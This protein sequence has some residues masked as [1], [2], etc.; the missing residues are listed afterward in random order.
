[1]IVVLAGG[2][3][4]ARF[5]EGVV[6]VVPPQEV[7]IISNTGD[8]L[9]FYGL[10]VCPDI[11]IVL[12]TLAGRLDSARGWGLLHDSF[13][14]LTSLRRFEP[15]VWFN[16]GDHDLATSLYRT[17]RLGEGATLTQLTAEIAAAQGLSVR[18]L[19]M[20]DE[21]VATR[22]LTPAGELAFQ[23]YFV[24]RRTEDEVLGIR[25]EGIEDARPVPGLLDAIGAAAA[26]IFAPSNPFVSIGPIL[27]VPGV[28]DALRQTAAPIVAISPIV[29]GEAIKGPAAKMFRSLGLDASPA[30]VARLYSDLLDALVIDQLDAELTPQVERAG[31]R[32]VVTDTI[33]RGRYEKANL[34]RAT[35]QAAGLD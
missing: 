10:R 30:G 9:D 13:N 7:T 21:R 14:V 29:G 5:L 27:A 32:A 22:I 4:A 25:F 31:V 23:E 20:S 16:L 19:P 11:D 28:R 12:Y 1:M 33:M 26:V 18:M 15:D 2:A 8:D 3:G 35:L 17:Q 24:R 6:T 34:A